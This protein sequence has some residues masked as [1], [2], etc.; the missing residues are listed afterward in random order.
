MTL[1]LE[2]LGCGNTQREINSQLMTLISSASRPVRSRL[3]ADMFTSYMAAT[4]ADDDDPEPKYSLDDSQERA[5]GLFFSKKLDDFG[6]KFKF[7]KK[8]KS[9]DLVA[10]DHDSLFPCDTANRTSEDILAKQQ[11][12]EEKKANTKPQSSWNV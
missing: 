12:A 9:Y 1:A 6:P 8:T 2:V 10:L 4:G 11:S 3:L 5:A 7:R